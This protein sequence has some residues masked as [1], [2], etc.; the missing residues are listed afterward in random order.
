VSNR[1]L[2]SYKE[3]PSYTASGIETTITVERSAAGGPGIMFIIENHDTFSG[4]VNTDSVMVDEGPEFL[5]PILEHLAARGYSAMSGPTFTQT[6]PIQKPKAQT[7]LEKATLLGHEARGIEQA[8][9]E[10]L[11]EDQNFRDSPLYVLLNDRRDELR[12]E[13]VKL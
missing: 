10:G 12:R 8:I 2:V 11:V 13:L 1:E 7:A 6:F 4:I 9:V 3:N 5:K